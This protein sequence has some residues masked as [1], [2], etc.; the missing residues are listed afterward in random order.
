MSTVFLGQQPSDVLSKRSQSMMMVI[1]RCVLSRMF[2]PRFSGQI[3]VPRAPLATGR[4]GEFP[5]NLFLNAKIA[6]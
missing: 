1:R 5:P 2:L 3:R 6:R 4:R